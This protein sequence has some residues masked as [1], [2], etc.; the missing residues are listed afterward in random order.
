LV[1]VSLFAAPDSS[2]AEDLVADQGVWVSATTA[3]RH[4]GCRA[5]CGFRMRGKEHLLDLCLRTIP[6]GLKLL[7]KT[8]YYAF[9]SDEGEV[10]A[11]L[12]KN[13]SERA[14]RGPWRLKSAST[15]KSIAGSAELTHRRWVCAQP[16]PRATHPEPR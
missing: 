2:L 14:H 10:L 7:G 13:D 12:K 4:A 3:L 11:F 16:Q 8:A 5:T 1:S 6:T 9:A 15:S